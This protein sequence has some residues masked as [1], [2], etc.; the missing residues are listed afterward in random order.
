LVKHAAPLAPLDAGDG[1]RDLAERSGADGIVL[2]GSRT[3]APV[4]V[5]LLD[6]VR[7]AVGAFP[8]WIG[9]GLTPANAPMLWP[10]CDGAIVGTF[11][12][13]DGKVSAPVD[14]DRVRTLR[15]ALD[16]LH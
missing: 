7:A 5:Q 10:K 14:A 11:C 15:K 8:V 6:T 9:S 3:G 2:S 12:K 13:R 16:A 4:D 1:A